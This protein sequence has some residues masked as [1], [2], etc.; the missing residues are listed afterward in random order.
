ME[1]SRTVRSFFILFFVLYL[2]LPPAVPDGLAARDAAPLIPTARETLNF[3]IYW[4][5]IC[6]GT[7]SLEAVHNNE[8]LTITSRVH[9]SQFLSVFYKVEDF[10]QSRIMKGM[11]RQFR[12]K[13]HEGRYRSDKETI[14]DLPNGKITFFNYLRDTRDDHT[15]NA[16]LVWDVISGFYYLRTR[17]LE[18]GK[19]VFVD[20]FDSNKF[21]SVAVHVLAKERIEVPWRGAV[22]T[23]KIRPV[24]HSEGLFQRKGDIIVWLTDD[25][26]KVPVKMETEV[27]VG[28]VTAQLTGIEKDLL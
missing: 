8:T 5:G 26:S 10:A 14:F 24:L 25:E 16:P 17:H 9:S 28:K 2:I 22:D 20:V 4:L 6:V 13:Q 12:I 27:S 21:L 7:A 11:P 1:I 19:T 15:V 18:V 23:V 3:A